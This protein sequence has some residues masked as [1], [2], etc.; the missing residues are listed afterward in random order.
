M[1]KQKPLKP[2]N[3]VLTKRVISLHQ[4]G[5]TD[6]FLPLNGLELQCLQSGESFAIKDLRINLIDSNYDRIT[7]SYLYIHTIDTGVGCRGLLM[8][9][10][11]LGLAN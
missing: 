4:I 7:R 1:K 8:T 5:Y 10:G 3:S 2:L 6:D 11:I 9:D